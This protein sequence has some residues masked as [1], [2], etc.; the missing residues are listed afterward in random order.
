MQ[1]QIQLC[2]RR[3]DE[4][5]ARWN[6]EVGWD[7]AVTSQ[8]ASTREPSDISERLQLF[9]ERAAAAGGPGPRATGI[10]AW[11]PELL[12]VPVSGQWTA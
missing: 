9:G 1:S 12:I 8:R 6:Q 10:I 3:P 2:A 4:V 5:S 11:K 7:A